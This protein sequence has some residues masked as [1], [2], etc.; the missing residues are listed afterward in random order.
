MTLKVCDYINCVES[1]LV[2]PLKRSILKFRIL[3]YLLILFY[4]L[5]TILISTLA[6][7]G[8]N[9][10]VLNVISLMLTVISGIIIMFLK[11]NKIIAYKKEH[12]LE[13]ICQM[14]MIRSMA[15]SEIRIYSNLRFILEE[16]GRD[17][18]I[19]ECIEEMKK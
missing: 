12:M 9:I 17:D 19:D 11:P 15:D 18:L 6:V 8:Y 16:H 14:D 10:A 4:I 5:P 13:I 1:K 3:K 2:V 7:F